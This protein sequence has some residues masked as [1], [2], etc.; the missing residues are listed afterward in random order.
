M[1]AAHHV[2]FACLFVFYRSL[3][4]NKKNNY[5]FFCS[6]KR[7]FFFPQSQEK[8]S[9]HIEVWKFKGI[10]TILPLDQASTHKGDVL[11]AQL[12]LTFHDPMHCSP[13]GSSDKGTHWRLCVNTPALSSLCG[14]WAVL[15]RQSWVRCLHQFTFSYRTELQLAL[16]ESRLNNV[17]F[18]LPFPV[19][20]FLS[21]V[22]IFCTSQ[23]Y[24]LH[25]NSFLSVC[26]WDKLNEH[27]FLFLLHLGC[28]HCNSKQ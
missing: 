24:L 9:F 18:L 16:W 14:K 17:F 20:P 6:H 23:M 19:S 5:L 3:N 26:F 11:V 13:P 27:S 25:S 12:C 10:I 1:A 7:I 15:Q 8:P 21:L 4:T 2:T 22:I 28:S